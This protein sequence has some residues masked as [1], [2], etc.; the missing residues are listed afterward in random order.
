[1]KQNMTFEMARN[2]IKCLLVVAGVMCGIALLLNDGSSQFA[3]WAAIIAVACIVAILFIVATAM[4]C[5]YCGRAIVR[6]CLVV[7]T[8]PHCNR[9]L[10]TGL[11]SK[12]KK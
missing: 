8:C 3:V 9:N 11:K 10:V 7:K 1:M 4:K 12:K 6:K 5:P 2:V